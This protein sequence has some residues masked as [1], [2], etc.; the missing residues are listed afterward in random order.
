MQAIP[1]AR[2]M[3]TFSVTVAVVSLL[4]F[5]V[6]SQTTSTSAARKTQTPPPS[7]IRTFSSP[8]DAANA[9]IDAAEKYDVPALYEILGPEARQI[10][11]TGEPAGDREQAM[12]FAAQAREKMSVDKKTQYSSRGRH[13]NRSATLIVGKEDWPFPVPVIRRDQK[14]S[15][16]TT[17]GLRELLLRRIGRNELDAI[18]ACRIYVEAQ[19]DYALLKREGTGVN[20]YAQRILSSP[21]KQDGLAWQNADGT[22]DGPLGPNIAA[23]VQRGYT[24]LNEPFHGYFFKV[25]K[26]Q[27]PAAPLGQLDWVVKGV[28]IG[29]F[30]L[31]ATPAQYRVTG[32]KSFIVSHDGVV[33]EK[34]LGPNSVQIGRATDRF[35]PDRTWR[36]V[37]EQ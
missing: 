24:N 32:V 16:F 17:V 9:L 37:A 10:I 1:I 28:M 15:F 12:A 4:V 19:H 5:D 22:W 25:L 23:A 13:S 2:R 20:Q 3:A 7:R 14:W 30:A 11:E 21:G 27:G 36:P 35:N 29:G 18:E 34:D 6:L 26:G 8:E 33:Y 31:I